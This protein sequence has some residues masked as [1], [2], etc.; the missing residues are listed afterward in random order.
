MQSE[1]K[2]LSGGEKSRSSSNLL[3]KLAEQLNSSNASIRRQAAFGLS[4]MQEDGLEIL[5]R[6]LFGSVPSRTKNAAAYG[7]R[8]M[9]GRMKKMAVEVFTQG[10]QHRD[11]STR[12]V[13]TNALVLMGERTAEPASNG[14]AAK[15]TIKDIPRKRKQRRRITLEPAGARRPVGT[16]G[17]STVRKP[18]RSR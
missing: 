7:L 9:R 5:K 1:E 16:R 2:G 17:P 12:G 3:E 10:L 11:G 6:T 18:R 8:K 4:W 13:C 14:P 15:P